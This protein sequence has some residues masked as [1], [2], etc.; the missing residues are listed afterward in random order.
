MP[1]WLSAPHGDTSACLGAPHPETV[2]QGLAPVS[3]QFL[4]SESCGA[5]S[6]SLEAGTQWGSRAAWTSCACPVWAVAFSLLPRDWS[7][8]VRPACVLDS[9]T[10][11]GH[12]RP[13]GGMPSDPR[14]DLAPDAHH[15]TSLRVISSLLLRK[16]VYGLQKSN[17]H[18]CH[19]L[20]H[21]GL[22]LGGS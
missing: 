10:D 4:S 7:V 1:S 13:L 15:F 11:D 9:L 12:W 16:Q 3:G 22:H 20:K 5:V 21:P 14:Q 18:T 17:M 6:T 2:L 8:G 19:F